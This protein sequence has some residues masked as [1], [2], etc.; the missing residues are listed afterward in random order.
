MYGNNSKTSYW[1]GKNR[2]SKNSIQQIDCEKSHPRI[3]TNCHPRKSTNRHPRMFLSGIHSNLSSPT[4]LGIQC[5]LLF[6]IYLFEKEI[7]PGFRIKCGMT[8]LMSFLRKRESILLF[9][10]FFCHSQLDWESTVSVIHEST[11]TD[12]L[13]IFY[14]GWQCFLIF[15][16]L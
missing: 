1:K 8:T 14:R 11:P 15:F 6:V 5:L 9:F 16:C 13:E 3:S 12:I 10:V 2:Q 4:W 7:L